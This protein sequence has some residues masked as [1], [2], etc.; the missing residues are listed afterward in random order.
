MSLLFPDTAP[1]VHIEPLHNSTVAATAQIGAYDIDSYHPKDYLRITSWVVDEDHVLHGA[2]KSSSL[3]DFVSN[4]CESCHFYRSYLIVTPDYYEIDFTIDGESFSAKAYEDQVRVFSP[5]PCYE[6]GIEDVDWPCTAGHDEPEEKQ[7]VNVLGARFMRFAI[8]RNIAPHRS[9]LERLRTFASQQGVQA[10]KDAND[11]NISMTVQRRTVN[12]YDPNHN[13]CWGQNLEPNN[14]RDV[15]ID[16]LNTPVNEDL[17]YFQ[18]HQFN[19]RQI[20]DK[21]AGAEFFDFTEGINFGTR[22]INEG[23]ERALVVTTAAHHPS[24]FLN[25]IAQGC[26]SANGICAVGV[27][28]RKQVMVCPGEPMDVWATPVLPTGQILLFLDTP[29]EDNGMLI[30]TFSPSILSTEPCELTTSP[31]SEPAAQAHC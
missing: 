10:K 1:P 26:W 16:Y 19:V 28:R 2:K 3:D 25:L 18:D 14:L 11:H 23:V 22:C 4:N 30:G 20:D 5:C 17:L 9:W 12:C 15:A 29:G 24:A 8:T 21:Y 7:V 6:K 13:I 31:S 27:F